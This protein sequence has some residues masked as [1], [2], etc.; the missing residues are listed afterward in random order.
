MPAPP[1]LSDPAML[2]AIGVLPVTG[3][4][5]SF[6]GMTSEKKGLRAEFACAVYPFPTPV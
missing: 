5:P 3:L 4:S 6:N 2:S 1:P